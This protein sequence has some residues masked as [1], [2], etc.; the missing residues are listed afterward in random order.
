MDG[1]QLREIDSEELADAL[2]VSRRTVSRRI[3]A[4]VLPRP[5]RPERPNRF[6]VDKLIAHV[7][8]ADPFESMRLVVGLATLEAI[9][10]QRVRLWSSR[11]VKCSA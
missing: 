6:A 11:P 1:Y 3:A 2:G 4:G 10:K 8:K 9:R 7:E 5:T